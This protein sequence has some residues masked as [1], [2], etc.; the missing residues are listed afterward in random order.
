MGYFEQIELITGESIQMRMPM[1]LAAYAFMILGL[2][3]ITV[4][5]IDD[6]TN[7]TLIKS[8]AQF[9]SCLGAVIY[10]VYA[11]TCS[12]IFYKFKLSIA[13]QD[14]LWGTFLYTIVPYVTFS[15]L[16]RCMD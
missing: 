12:A 14:T 9:G 1:A 15:V 13:I 10:G 4:P 2:F 3:V 7:S 11:F 5:N 8:C 16:R 6:S